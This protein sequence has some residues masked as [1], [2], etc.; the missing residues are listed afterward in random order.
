MA[1]EQPARG[2]RG[3]RDGSVRLQRLQRVARAGGRVAAAETQRRKQRRQERGQCEAIS[4]HGEN[5]AV[6]QHV[7]S[8]TAGRTF[9][10]PARPRATLKSFATEVYFFPTI[11]ARATSTRSSG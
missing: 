10:S 11:E 5:Q 1:S 4:A 8:I 6:L 3:A 2:E 7:H 9:S